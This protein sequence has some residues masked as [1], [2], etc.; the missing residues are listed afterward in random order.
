MAAFCSAPRLLSVL[1]YL[2]LGNLESIR[3]EVCN[4]LLITLMPPR[5]CINEHSQC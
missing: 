4:A 3:D 1:T 5:C 2:L